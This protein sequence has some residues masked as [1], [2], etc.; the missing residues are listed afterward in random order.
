MLRLKLILG[1]LFCFLGISAQIIDN[2]FEHEVYEYEI[3][4][5]SDHV[6]LAEDSDEENSIFVLSKDTL[7][8]SLFITSLQVDGTVHWQRPSEPINAVERFNV[9]D[10]FIF[11]SDQEYNLF[12]FDKES[13]FIDSINFY[14]PVYEFVVPTGSGL[15]NQLNNQYIQYTTGKEDQVNFVVNVNLL[16]TSSFEY[17][18]GIK[19]INYDFSENIYEE[20][21][22]NLSFVEFP[23]LFS[24]EDFDEIQNQAFVKTVRQNGANFTHHID[25]N[26]NLVETYS[27]TFSPEICVED[28]TINI[29]YYGGV[30][31]IRSLETSFDINY[32]CFNKSN[33]SWDTSLSPIRE[34]DCERSLLNS[35]GLYCGID[36]ILDGT[37]PSTSHVLDNLSAFFQVAG[38]T[39]TIIDYKK[40][41]CFDEDGDGYSS[42]YD[43]D[44]QDPEFNPGVDD[45]VGNDV[46]ENCDG[47]LEF[48]ED[49]DGVSS[50][51]DC[52]D[53]DPNIG[54]AELPIP[55]S[56]FSSFLVDRGF[57]LN[58]NYR[59]ECYEALLIDTL[60]V[61][62]FGNVIGE[63]PINFAAFPNLRYLELNN[64]GIETIDV[65]G[66]SQLRHLELRGNK[67]THI[68]IHNLDSLKYLNLQSN[69]I[70]SLNL[71]ELKSLESLELFLNNL[72]E[73]DLTDLGSLENL[74][75]L[76]LDKNYLT[77][78]KFAEIDF[79]MLDKLERL[80]LSDNALENTDFNNLNLTSL[81]RLYLSRNRLEY[82]TLCGLS[83]LEVFICSDCTNLRSLNIKNDKI[84]NYLRLEDLSSLEFVCADEDQIADV[85]EEINNSSV[86]VSS[87][88]QEFPFNGQDDD[89]DPSFPFNGQ[90][91]DC[92]PSTLDNDGDQ[93]GYSVDDDCNDAN[94]EVNPNMEEVVYD[95]R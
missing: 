43:C 80:E 37:Y 20:R 83:S 26:G 53:T 36:T 5:L 6:V 86:I 48:D 78:D 49:G 46:D 56:D 17:T 19:V 51:T 75:L 79:S 33:V 69:N 88:C 15:L 70:S 22:Q 16:D 2:I 66:L 31:E 91:D 8:E 95:V 47:I 12:R 62:H 42:V 73:A 76:E 40:D 82:I 67:L 23:T 35:S 1:F 55:G 64:Q 32:K 3:S 57:D 52:D 85:I 4:E 59:I 58:Q 9:N 34:I 71:K 50:L 29:G 63:D 41:S 30:S 45:I 10:D 39:L 90:D 44:D 92:D 94:P 54:S 7:Q 18:S 61:D 65:N 77:D 81:K 24:V 84:E 93:D 21:F 74:I 38:T 25:F 14:D 60:I 13:N 89:C 11:I 28:V 72:A 27:A 68:D 87:Q